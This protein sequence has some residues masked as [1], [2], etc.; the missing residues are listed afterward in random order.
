[1]NHSSAKDVE[2]RGHVIKEMFTSA[3][4]QITLVIIIFEFRI[5][6]D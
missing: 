1:M 6:N 3:M 4:I 5:S 2:E